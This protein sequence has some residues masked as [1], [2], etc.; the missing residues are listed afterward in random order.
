MLQFFRNNQLHTSFFV[1]IASLPFLWAASNSSEIATA[2]DLKFFIAINQNKS[3]A[4]AVF[5]ILLLSQAF[6]LNSLI[7]YYRIGKKTSFYTAIILQQFI[8]TLR[9][10]TTKTQ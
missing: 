1:I 10:T 6:W 2:N 5:S 7:N 9:P 8:N 4:L 3:I